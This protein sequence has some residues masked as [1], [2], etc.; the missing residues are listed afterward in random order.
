MQSNLCSS[1]CKASFLSCPKICEF[2]HRVVGWRMLTVLK[3]W[4][5][6]T[7][8]L[9]VVPS[10]ITYHHRPLSKNIDNNITVVNHYYQPLVS[11][12][13]II[14]YLFNKHEKL[15][16][17]RFLVTKS[18]KATTSSAATGAAERSASKRPTTA[19]EQWEHG[20][21]DTTNEH[22]RWKI[23]TARF[24]FQRLSWC[25]PTYWLAAL[26]CFR[27]FPSNRGL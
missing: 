25:D 18:A 5:F 22:P 12:T 19:V 3:P 10:T 26:K 16:S 1:K 4:S 6:K 23:S 2:A 13:I 7:C 17:C 8:W 15:I 24:S 27:Y 9:N 20:A 11:T 21:P 14:H